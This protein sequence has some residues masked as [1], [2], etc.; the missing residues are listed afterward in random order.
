MKKMRLVNKLC[1]VVVPVLLW[2]SA[3]YAASA[4]VK[5]E[6]ALRQ[7]FPQL[8]FDKIEQSDIKGAYE[9][10]SGQNIYYFFPETEYLFVGE[11]YNKQG[12]SIT[13]QKKGELGAKLMKDLPLEKAVKIGNGKKVVVEFTD[14]DCPY[15]K[16]ASEYFK[17]RTDV[18][19]YVFFAPLAHPGAM[20]KIHFILNAEDKAKAYSEMMLDKAVA[21]PPAVDKESVKALAQEHLALAK[22]VGVQGT[23]TFF[24]NGRLVVGAD[25]KQI[26][27]LLKDDGSK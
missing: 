2:T 26:E 3:G 17:G 18:T 27:Q 15:C 12:Q 4:A 25:I 24:I 7:A 16:K 8:T 9:V 1:A 20:P 5:P 19:R 11:V 6:V 10:T 22:K 23:P 14:P 13:A 21:P